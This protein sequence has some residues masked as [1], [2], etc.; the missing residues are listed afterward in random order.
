[1]FFGL[2]QVL[3]LLVLGNGQKMG[4]THVGSE[5]IDELVVFHDVPAIA[6]QRF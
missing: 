6:D 1:M 5:S 2:E 4:L 3:L